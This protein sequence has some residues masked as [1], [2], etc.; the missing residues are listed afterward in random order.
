MTERNTPEWRA[1][2]ADALA[3]YERDTYIPPDGGEWETRLYAKLIIAANMIR[4]NL[5]S[6]RE[7][8]DFMDIWETVREYPLALTRYREDSE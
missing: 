8:D 1:A 4:P 6:V 2:V 5:L 3:H 7:T